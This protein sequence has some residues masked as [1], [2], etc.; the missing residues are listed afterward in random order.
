MSTTTTAPPTPGAEEEP[1][2]GGKKKLVIVA[3]LVL[4][5]GGAGYWFFLKPAGPTPPPE[6]GE[7]MVMEPVQINLEG[8]RYLRIGI[9]LQL[10]KAA[11]DADGSKALDAVIDLFSGRDIAEISK[12]KER[13]ELKEELLETLVDK[14]EGKVMGVYFTEFVTQ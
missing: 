12:A 8:G 14:Y 1:A 4:V 7:V 6:P 13:Q 11:Y 3:A 2:K 5:L 9:A 10:T